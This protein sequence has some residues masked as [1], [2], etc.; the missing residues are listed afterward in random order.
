MG[1]PGSEVDL[2]EGTDC[3]TIASKSKIKEKRTQGWWRGGVRK[4]RGPGGMQEVRSHISLFVG[5]PPTN[6][7]E[8][9]WSQR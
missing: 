1:F 7:R 3:S 8:E 2:T 6:P 9:K 5:E 4:R